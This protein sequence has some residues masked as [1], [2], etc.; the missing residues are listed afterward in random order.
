MP[1]EIANLGLLIASSFG[2]FQFKFR[3]LIGKVV[4]IENVASL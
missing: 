1:V 2:M 3:E 4:L